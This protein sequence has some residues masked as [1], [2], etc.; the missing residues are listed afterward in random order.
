MKEIESKIV[1]ANQKDAHFT[2]SFPDGIEGEP[3]ICF[4][5]LNVDCAEE[6]KVTRLLCWRLQDI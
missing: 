1:G 5:G 4:V 6:S 2:V 3:S